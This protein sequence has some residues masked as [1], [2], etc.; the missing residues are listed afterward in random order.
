MYAA[1][2]TQNRELWCEHADEKGMLAIGDALDFSTYLARNKR[3]SWFD[4]G[5]KEELPGPAGRR[6]PSLSQ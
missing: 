2:S 1:S 6:N 5:V 4:P 3:I